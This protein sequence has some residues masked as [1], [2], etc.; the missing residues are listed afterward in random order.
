MFIDAVCLKYFCK[1]KRTLTLNA[2]KLTVVELS[3]CLWYK[4]YLNLMT[5]SRKYFKQNS[6]VYIV[7]R[8]FSYGHK[9]VN[10]S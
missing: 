3:K 2:F 10:Y 7:H 5:Y 1:L 8:D 6:V 9:F 4:S